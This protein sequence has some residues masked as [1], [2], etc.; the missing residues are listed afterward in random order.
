MKLSNLF[1]EQNI[2]D[3]ITLGYLYL[4]ILGIINIV[5]YYSAFGVNIFDY[6]TITDILLAPVNMLFLDYWFTLFII[7]ALLVVAFLSKFLISGLN[8]IIAKI[9]SNDQKGLPKIVIRPFLIFV[10]IF[11]YVFLWLSNNMAES[12]SSRV[13][14]KKYGRETELTFVDNTSKKV[15]VIATTS[16]YVFYI[17][18]GETDV[19]ISPISGTIKS[20]KKMQSK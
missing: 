18:K 6:I 8:A 15:F 17:N 5:I 1:K 14:T 3:Y 4:V 12:M 16:M 9:W 10:I 7:I 19:S 2:Q 20:I 13:K 11:S